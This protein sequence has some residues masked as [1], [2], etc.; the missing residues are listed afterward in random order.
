ML[1]KY[2]FYK[3]LKD[4]YQTFT[5]NPDE[6]DKDDYKQAWM[7]KL[8]NVFIEALNKSKALSLFC[9]ENTKEIEENSM[10]FQDS[11]KLIDIPFHK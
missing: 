8:K 1:G 11:C 5:I 4:A 9:L 10:R 3:S 7:N 6:I 2:K